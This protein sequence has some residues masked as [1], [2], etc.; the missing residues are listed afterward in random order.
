MEKCKSYDIIQ[1]NKNFT[2]SGLDIN[3]GLFTDAL[4]T[5]VRFLHVNS[6]NPTVGSPQL[7]C[8]SRSHPR[9]SGRNR[10]GFGPQEAE[11]PGQKADIDSCLD[12]IEN[13]SLALEYNS[14]NK[15]TDA[16]LL[17]LGLVAE[18]PRHG[19]ELEQI[20]EERGMREWT[21]NWFLVDI[22]C[23]RQARKERACDGCSSSWR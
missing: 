13:H 21:S 22:F 17:L 16:E 23:A 15:V 1:P 3:K 10:Q 11:A 18:M 19:Y 12:T 9:S 7:C 8:R 5:N 14:A 6:E 4:T 20:I 2:T